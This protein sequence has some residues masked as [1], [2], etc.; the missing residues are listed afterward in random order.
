MD[1]DASQPESAQGPA[2]TSPGSPS[3][4]GWGGGYGPYSPG[5]PLPSFPDLGSN[6]LLNPEQ[7]STD[8][9][10]FESDDESPS[11]NLWDQLPASVRAYLLAPGTPV[12]ASGVAAQASIVSPARGNQDIDNSTLAPV[13]KPLLTP[14]AHL[15]AQDD[16]FNQISF[17]VDSPGGAKNY[18]PETFYP[19]ARVIAQSH[20][21]DAYAGMQLG[22][23]DIADAQRYVDWF[24]RLPPNP[25]AGMDWNGIDFQPRASGLDAEQQASQAENHRLQDKYWPLAVPALAPLAVAAAPAVLAASDTGGAWLATRAPWTVPLSYGLTAGALGAPTAIQGVSG[26]AEEAEAGRPDLSAIPEGLH[27]VQVNRQ[28][29]LA[30]QARAATMKAANFN[31]VAEEVAIR[32]HTASGPADFFVRPDGIGRHP[33]T[34]ELHLWDAKAGELPTFTPNQQAGYD[35]IRRYGGTIVGKNGGQLYP[36]GMYVPPTEVDTVRPIDLILKTP[37]FRFGFQMPP[38]EQT[39]NALYGFGSGDRPR[40]TRDGDRR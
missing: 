9:S 20:P 7:A 17:R 18:A 25:Y 26:L 15:Q 4:T 19:G 24:Q 8:S 36:E 5:Y 23:D 21:G 27:P 40:A 16:D 28:I 38:L 2:S 14:G 13:P 32:P 11:S 34:G 33:A 12:D 3:A 1:L 10:D 22:S 30:H 37:P 31:D 35:L 6:R 39:V 29:G